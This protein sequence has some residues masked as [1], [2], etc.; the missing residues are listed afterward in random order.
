M[1]PAA[2]IQ[3]KCYAKSSLLLQSFCAYYWP[4]W[5]VSGDKLNTVEASKNSHV[6]KCI[7]TV[8]PHGDWVR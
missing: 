6:Q 4:H 8:W 2:R 5:A 7:I 3:Q 1:L